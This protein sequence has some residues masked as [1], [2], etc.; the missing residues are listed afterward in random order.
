VIRAELD[1]QGR[2]RELHSVLTDRKLAG[3]R[4]PEAG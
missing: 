1:A 2:I 3:V 4:M